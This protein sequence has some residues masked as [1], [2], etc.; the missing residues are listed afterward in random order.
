MKIARITNQ[1]N[2]KIADEIIEYPKELEGGRNLVVLSDIVSS[3]KVEVTD[4]GWIVR[5]SYS[6]VLNYNFHVKLEPNTEY[7]VSYEMEII[8]QG[9]TTN[10]F[11]G[12]LG[13]T[14]PNPWLL[15]T[16]GGSNTTKV[17]DSFITDDLGG[18]RLTCYGSLGGVVEFKNVK[19]E[20][21]N[22]VTPYTPAP[23]DLGLTY[24][25]D[26]NY[27]TTSFRNNGSLLVGEIIKMEPQIYSK[28]FIENGNYEYGE[29]EPWIVYNGAQLSWDEEVG[30]YLFQGTASR[31]DLA[32]Q[33]LTLEPHTIY[34]LSLMG[35]RQ[36]GNTSIRI[37]RSL[38]GED[39]IANIALIGTSL[40]PTLT[41]FITEGQTQYYISFASTGASRRGYAKEI[42]LEKGDIAS[43]YASY[44]EVWVEDKLPLMRFKDGKVYIKGELIEGGV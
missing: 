44:G 37:L 36:Y 27:F 10:T 29:I 31:N 8:E 6:T 40:A 11:P 39:Y 16:F 32:Y 3:T 9:D 35:Q 24:D 43:E 19:I 13:V 28:N 7:T 20:K 1:G 38:E 22:K 23:E 18:L 15:I 34:T 12:R 17:V 14:R 25:N 21:G 41:T 2:L 30:A 4:T 42:Q 5:D 26:I 33:E